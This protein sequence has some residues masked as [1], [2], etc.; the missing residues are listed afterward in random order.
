MMGDKGGSG[1]W[2]GEGEEEGE[3]Q[4][5]REYE[6]LAF[7]TPLFSC[8]SVFSPGFLIPKTYVYHE[9]RDE[10]WEGCLE[11]AFLHVNNDVLQ[12]GR[13]ICLPPPVCMYMYIF[14]SKY[15]D[16]SHIWEMNFWCS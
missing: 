4:R 11:C 16:F 3:G 14:S 8:A 1:E 9:R 10:D 15:I 6:S 5:Q 2:G 12:P 13:C 7:P